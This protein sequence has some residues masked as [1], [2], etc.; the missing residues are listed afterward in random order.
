MS[1]L[2]KHSVSV[3]LLDLNMPYV[4]VFE[5][6]PKIVEGYPETKVIVVSAINEDKIKTTCMNIGAFEYFKKPVEPTALIC[7]IK[8]ASIRAAQRSE[9]LNGHDLKCLL[10]W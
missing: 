4:S 1:L 7:S 3:I 2:E 5:L 6:L 10:Q 9:R 8:N